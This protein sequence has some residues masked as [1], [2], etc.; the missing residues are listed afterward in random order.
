VGRPPVE[1]PIPVYVTELR[2]RVVA[3]FRVP[4]RALASHVPAPVMPDLVRGEGV[5]ALCLGNGRCLKSVGGHP[6]LASEFH[7]AELITPAYWQAACRP[8]LKGNCLLAAWSDSHG[9]SRLIRTSLHLAAGCEPE[10]Q[11][12]QKSTY[13]CRASGWDL[14]LEKADADWPA[15]SLFSSAETAEGLLLH[16]ECYFVPESREGLVRAV[17]VH[18]YARSAVAARALRL[19]APVVA[20]VLGLDSTEVTPDHVF[21]Q[22]RCTHTWFFPPERIPVARAAPQWSVAPAGMRRAA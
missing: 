19:E 16:P 12:G 10:E 17:P 22:K 6:V 15:G 1:W 18:Q 2:D 14:E 3:T 5:V 11:G 7:V 21:L 9:L 13:R 20:E 8:A 4:G